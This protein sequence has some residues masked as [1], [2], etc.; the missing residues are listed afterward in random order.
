MVVNFNLLL[1]CLCL[2]WMFTPGGRQ[3]GNA[4][5][6][7]ALRAAAAVCFALHAASLADLLLHA[8]PDP[9]A[10]WSALAAVFEKATPAVMPANFMAFDFLGVLGAAAIFAVA[11]LCGLAGAAAMLTKGLV[12]GPGAAF[13]LACAEREARLAAGAAAA[14]PPEPESAFAQKVLARSRAPAG[15]RA[16]DE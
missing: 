16:K 6:A 12:I 7:T 11:E 8:G 1:P 15:A 3:P 9:R 10:V 13:A 4:A 5:A 14:P 2:L